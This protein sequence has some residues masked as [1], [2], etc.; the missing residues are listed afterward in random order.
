M[1]LS[2]IASKS[3]TREIGLVSASCPN[4]LDITYLAQSDCEAPDS[5]Q[6]AL[7]ACI[8]KIDQSGA[9]YDAIVLSYG[10]C[11][12]GVCGISSEHYSLVIPRVHNHAALLLG[13]KERFR[14]LFEQYP[15]TFWFTPG[16]FEHSQGVMS[17]WPSP[18][19]GGACV[20]LPQ[21]TTLRCPAPAHAAFCGNDALVRA[22]LGGEWDDRFLVIPPRHTC[23][24]TYR[25]DL[26]RL[27]ELDVE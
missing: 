12:G 5:L 15:D 13:D 8:D 19:T 24:P 6:C 1:R 11:S 25:A 22:L 10:L 27:A 14:L 7:Q 2:V 23:E 20:S 17:S 18:Y 9:G 16:Y 4:S 26:L 3:L 21:A